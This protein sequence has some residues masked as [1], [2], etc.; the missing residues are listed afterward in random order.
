[1]TE[2]YYPPLEEKIASLRSGVRV[3]VIGLPI[4]RRHV[5]KLIKSKRMDVEVKALAFGQFNKGTRSQYDY[6]ILVGINGRYRSAHDFYFGYGPT[7][8]YYQKCAGMLS[9]ASPGNERRV[10]MG[11]PPRHIMTGVVLF[12][13]LGASLVEKPSE[14]LT[15]PKEILKP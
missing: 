4:D 11:L 6:A 7:M 10:E 3:A 1:M 15:I 8:A 9:S 14:I 2:Q 5:S 12:R 13:D